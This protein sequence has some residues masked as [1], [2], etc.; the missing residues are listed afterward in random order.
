MNDERLVECD[1]CKLWVHD[2]CDGG[3]APALESPEVCL[4]SI[5]FVVV[6]V[7]TAFAVSSSIVGIVGVGGVA[8]YCCC[9]F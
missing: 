3:V 4:L 1:A 9:C 2:K 8:V 6:A 5:L 7:V